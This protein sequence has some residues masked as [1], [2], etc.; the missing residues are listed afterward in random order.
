MLSIDSGGSVEHVPLE[1]AFKNRRKKVVI[2]SNQQEF[3]NAKSCLTKINAFEDELTAPVDELRAVGAI[4]KS[5]CWSQVVFPRAQ[6]WGR[7]CL[8]SLSTIWTSQSSVPSCVDNTKLGRSVDLFEG[9]KAL[10]RD[11]DR[12][13]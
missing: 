2:R 13:D 9:R 11:L 5:S 7:F 12:L 3:T 1:Y 10:Q 8:I 4:V 6:H